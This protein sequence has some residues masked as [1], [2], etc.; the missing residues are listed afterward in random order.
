MIG[1]MEVEGRVR[2]FERPPPDSQV[3]RIATTIQVRKGGT[4][5]DLDY[6]SVFIEMQAAW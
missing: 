4:G 3:Q 2:G 5:K 6:D 1:G